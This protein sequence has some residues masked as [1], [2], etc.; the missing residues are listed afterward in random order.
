MQHH[1]DEVK[2]EMAHAVHHVVPTERERRQRAVGEVL[3]VRASHGLAC[4]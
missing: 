2:S 4:G 1:I 3:C